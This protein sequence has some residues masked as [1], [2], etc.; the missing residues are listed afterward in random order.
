MQLN[1]MPMYLKHKKISGI[2]QILPLIHKPYQFFAAHL[3]CF[4]NLSIILILLG[5]QSGTYRICVSFW[6]R[7]WLLYSDETWRC[8]R[9]KTYI[10]FRIHYAYRVYDW[11]SQYWKPIR[12][13]FF[14]IY[15]WIEC[16]CQ[17]LCWLH[18]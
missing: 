1:S 9:E 7:D 18:L 8:L 12:W 10:Y 4:F 13:I 17:V 11:D 15:I 5:F 3:L 6:N 16:D 2:F 14:N